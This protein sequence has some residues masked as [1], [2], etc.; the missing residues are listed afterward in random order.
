MASNQKTIIIVVAVALAVGAGIG[1]WY[2]QNRNATP[3]APVTTAP[4][5][6]PTQAAST[7]VIQEAG[8]SIGTVIFEKTQEPLKDK[9]PETNPLKRV[10]INPF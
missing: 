1:F 2:W 4:A 5:T 9:L 6:S 8:G 10:M 7:T 3:A